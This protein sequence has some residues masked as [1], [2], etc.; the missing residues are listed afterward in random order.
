MDYL[1]TVPMLEDSHGMKQK[2][3]QELERVGQV[4][5]RIKSKLDQVELYPEGT[6]DK[7]SCMLQQIKSSLNTVSI[8][9]HSLGTL[10][11]FSQVFSQDL[12]MIQAMTKHQCVS[13]LLH[14]LK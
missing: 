2:V 12:L 3:Q 4:M 1:P 13:F 9:Q 14:R 5:G 8:N 7:T 6:R 10:R 11:L